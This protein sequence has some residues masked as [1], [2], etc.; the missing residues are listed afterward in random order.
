MGSDYVVLMICHNC[1]E[2]GRH[3][4][5][6]LEGSWIVF[7]GGSQILQISFSNLFLLNRTSSSSII[8]VYEAIFINY[9]DSDDSVLIHSLIEDGK[10]I[11]IKL[12][13]IR[14]SKNDV[15]LMFLTNQIYQMLLESRVLQNRAGH[16]NHKGKI[17]RLRS[18]WCTMRRE[19][20]EAWGVWGVRPCE[21][22]LVRRE[23]RSVRLGSCD[24]WAA[25]AMWH[26]NRVFQ[27]RRPWNS[28]VQN[29][30]SSSVFHWS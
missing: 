18:V 5:T 20:Y 27:N 10:K 19:A 26:T 21:A 30:N 28:I 25:N 11:E 7:Q 2:R 13:L 4:N 1:G 9:E 24:A 6:H 15:V 8:P 17:M 29:F 3:L 12:L 22:Q 16:V 23:A 14:V